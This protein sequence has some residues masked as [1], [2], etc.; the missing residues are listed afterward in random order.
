M[1]SDS[2]ITLNINQIKDLIPQRYPFLMVDRVLDLIQGEKILALKNLSANE[3]YFQGHFP[4]QPIMPGVLAC[5]AMAQ[6]SAL[7]LSYGKKK[8][9]ETL[10][11]I[12]MIKKMQFKF[13]LVPGDALQIEMRIERELSQQC[14][15]DGSIT[16]EGKI[17]VTGQFIFSIQAMEHA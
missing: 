14:F 6:A 10:S 13:P 16:V 9:Q 11:L 2:N 1:H 5:E 4:Q 8:G 12:G 17:A 3:P 15:V 7:L